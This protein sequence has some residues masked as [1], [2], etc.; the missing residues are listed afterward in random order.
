MRRVINKLWRLPD[1]DVNLVSIFLFIKNSLHERSSMPIKRVFTIFTEPRKFL[2]RLGT[3]LVIDKAERANEPRIK[4]K[5][6]E[7]KKMKKTLTTTILAA[8]MMLAATFANAGII[9]SD[10]ADSPKCEPAA[11]EG[12]IVSDSPVVNAIAA[13]IEGII[14]S[15]KA[16]SGTCTQKEGIIVSDRTEG[17]I[18]SD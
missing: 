17:I 4:L 13:W 10:K 6:L 11:K 7:E 12:I 15:D 8:T 3:R 1:K 14:V 2:A 5:L 16:D 18:V 9:V